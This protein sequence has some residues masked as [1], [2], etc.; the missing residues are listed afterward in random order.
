MFLFSLLCEFTFGGFHFSFSFVPRIMNAGFF[1]IFFN[2]RFLCR[3]T[4]QPFLFRHK[5]CRLNGVQ[6][7]LLLEMK[8]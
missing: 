3:Y 7:H 4:V 5:N 1:F 2:V 8:V 6:G